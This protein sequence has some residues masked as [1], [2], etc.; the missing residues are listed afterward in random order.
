LNNNILI[1]PEFAHTDIGLMKEVTKELI[2]CE[3]EA[4]LCLEFVYMMLLVIAL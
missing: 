3:T 4:E 2:E 1:V